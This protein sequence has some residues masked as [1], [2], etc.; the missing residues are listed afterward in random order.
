MSTRAATISLRFQ[1]VPAAPGQ[2]AHI[3]GIPSVSTHAASPT[4]VRA[5]LLGKLTTY[6]QDALAAAASPEREMIGCNDGTVLLV[7]YH[8]AWAHEIAGPGR[9]HACATTGY[10]SFQEAR[11]GAVRHADQSYGGV[12]WQLRL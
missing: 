5:D 4:R 9:K 11:E 8:G 2:P 3:E 10:T 1:V 7:A 6:V 12:A